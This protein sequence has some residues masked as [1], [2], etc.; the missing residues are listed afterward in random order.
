[1][2]VKTRLWTFSDTGGCGKS[3]GSGVMEQ[4]QSRLNRQGWE[5]IGKWCFKEDIGHELLER[6][7][8]C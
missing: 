6:K 1:M 4:W 2:V 7:L 5:E 3:M 8:K